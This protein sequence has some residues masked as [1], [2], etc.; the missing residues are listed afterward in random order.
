MRHLYRDPKIWSL[1]ERLNTFSQRHQ[2][3]LTELAFGWLL[4]HSAVG[5]VIAGAT[6]EDQILE[7][8]ASVACPLTPEELKGVDVIL[9]AAAHDEDV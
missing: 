5:S 4:H 3:K 2:R 7:N 9:E 1:V 8:V 6:S